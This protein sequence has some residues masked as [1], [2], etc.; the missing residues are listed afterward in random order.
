MTLRDMK[1]LAA[2]IFE[3]KLGFKPS[4]KDIVLLESS[5]H[6]DNGHNIVD[7]ISF[8][9]LGF[10]RIRYEAHFAAHDWDLRILDTI[11]NADMYI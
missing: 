6:E 3:Q 11:T 8:Q 2:Q 5:E 1:I 7:N 4:S 9:R 10:S